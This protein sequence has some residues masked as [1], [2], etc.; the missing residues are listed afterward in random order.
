MFGQCDGPVGLVRHMTW[1]LR[2]VFKSLALQ[3]ERSV[4]VDPAV[5]HRA[6]LYR[7]PREGDV[8]AAGDDAVHVPLQIL[9]NPIPPHAGQE[10]ALRS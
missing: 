5:L 8:V 10:V 4:R 1:H 2:Q 3:I 7:P 9:E 6:P